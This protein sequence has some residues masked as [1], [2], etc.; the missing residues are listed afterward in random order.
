MI[1]TP[2]LSVLVVLDG[3]DESAF[4]SRVLAEHLDSVRAVHDVATALRVMQDEPFDLVFVSLSLPRGDGLAFVH[5]VRALH[6]DTDVVVIASR[7]EI[8]ESG[9]AMALGVLSTVMRP[10]TGDALLV[11]ADRARERRLLMQERARLA[12]V[13][14]QNLLRA[15]TYARCAGFISET[16]AQVVAERILET[17][18]AELELHAGAVYLPRQSMAGGF[19][20]AA[21]FGAVERCPPGPTGADL[22]ELDPVTGLSE[23]DGA[24]RLCLVGPLDVCAVVD[25]CPASSDLGADVREALEM[26]AALGTA[27]LVASGKAEAIARAG[28]K[29]PDT[30]AYTFAYF[31]DVAGREI[32]R[33]V[34]HGRRFAL[35]TVSFPAPPD[36]SPSDAAPL[37]ELRRRVV[38]VLLSAIRD[39][40]VLA[41]VDD[42]ELYLLLPETGLLGALSARRRVLAQLEAA[43]LELSG[44]KLPPPAVGVAVYPTDGGDLGRLLRASRRRAEAEQSGVS[45][46][47]GLSRRPFWERVDLLLGGEDDAIMVSGD[48]VAMHPDLDRTHD[49]IG[50]SRH[51]TFTPGLLARVGAGLAS[52]ALRHEAAGSIY[53]AGDP[54]VAE[55][56]TAA[57]Q[58]SLGRTRVWSL[59]HRAPQVDV[60]AGDGRSTSRPPPPEELDSGF[61][62]AVQDPRLEERAF[63]LSVTELGAYAVLA[64]RLSPSALIGFHSADLFLVDGLV[65]SLRQRYH[66]QP[67][68]HR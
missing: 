61:D 28:I 66:L 4:V 36:G 5:H 30:S 53:V 9:H 8:A 26:V 68:P 64:R 24:L 35:M 49:A 18:A 13:G 52:D 57:A 51:A 37:L 39:S 23:K 32:D 33:A 44:T 65:E 45:R 12:Q 41:R 38:D 62:L 31:G 48:R 21:T 3:E 2:S 20:R 6:P 11:A 54:V 19:A 40:D 27:A 59:G 25:L 50:L 56:V 47:L 42:E 58:G 7:A 43:A 34:R 60:S 63:L 17:C 15:R 46:R 22:D 10:L 1:E 67:E 55:A 14:S 16:S 29:D